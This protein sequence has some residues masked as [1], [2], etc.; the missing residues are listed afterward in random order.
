MGSDMIIAIIPTS[1][2][3]EAGLQAADNFL[4][5]L[6]RTF[7]RGEDRFLQLLCP[8]CSLIIDADDTRENGYGTYYTR[9]KPLTAAALKEAEGY[10]S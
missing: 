10:R 2:V 6:Q 9:K 4:W 1:P 7:E 5:A 3:H 8:Q